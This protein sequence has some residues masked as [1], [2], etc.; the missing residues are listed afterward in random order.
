V[1]MYSLYSA[2]STLYFSPAGEMMIHCDRLKDHMITS[3]GSCS[4]HLHTPLSPASPFG[5]HDYLSGRPPGEKNKLM[6]LLSQVENSM[7]M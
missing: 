7:Y 1:K 6:E 3:L 4:T 2:Y 5:S